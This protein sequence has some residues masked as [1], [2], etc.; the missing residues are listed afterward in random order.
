[1][2]NILKL[3]P[4]LALLA[5]SAFTVQA[6]TVY[7]GQ[8][9]TTNTTLSA[10]V[11]AQATQSGVF[12]PQWCVASATGI[13]LPSLSG[14]TVGSYLFVDKEAAQVYGQGTSSTCFLVRRGALTTSANYAH[15]SGATVWVGNPAVS[16]GDNSRPFSGAFI[17]EPPSGTCTASAQYSLPVIVTGSATAQGL[18]SGD[19]YYCRGGY[20]A[21]GDA[22]IPAAPYTS[23]TTLALPGI[24]LATMAASVTDVNGKVF[25]SQLSVPANATLTG[26]CLLNAATATTDK[27]IYIL[28]DGAGNVVATTA[29]AGTT[30][31][32]AS[33][34]QCL[35]FTNKVNVQGPGTYF[36][37]VQGNGT[38]STFYAYT[39]GGNTTGYATAAVTGGTFGTIA[40]IAPSTTFHD[41]TG[42]LMSTY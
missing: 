18:Y 38:T 25:Y 10:A 34:Y 23:F 33:Q 3:G 22:Q 16:S 21:K 17:P 32:G 12:P 20:W 26:A 27:V 41:V 28:W 30:V 13:V 2:R 36:I 8:V 4:I 24:P 6:A 7:G 42:P 5:A 35:A 9:D 19:V 1:M 31:S 39:T 37:G 29:L 40:A 11:A 14:N 15:A